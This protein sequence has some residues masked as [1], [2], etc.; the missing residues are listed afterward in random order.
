MGYKIG[1]VDAWGSLIPAGTTDKWPKQFW[2]IFERYGV[3][4]RFTKGFTAEQI[5]A[6]MDEADVEW[7]VLSAFGYGDFEI[8]TNEMV[9]ELVR[10]HPD[11][12]VGAGT[13]DP[14]GKPMDVTAQVDYLVNDLGLRCIRLEPYAYGN[15]MT[16]APPGEK[17][18]WP[19][20]IKACELGVPVAIQVGHTGPLLPSECGRPIYLDE[21]ALAFPDLKIL[22]CHLGQPWHEEMMILAWK[23]PNLYVETSARYASHWPESFTKFAGSYGQDKVVWATDYPLCGFK[24]AYDDVVKLGFSD[25]ANEKILRT[26]AMRVF[27]IEA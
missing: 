8:C 6:E 19:V 11:R 14:R 2:S 25:E 16:G 21:V 20:Y 9:S 3:A 15:D 10:A 18:Y 23:H 24:R 12:F 26:N 5:L 22:G 1:A 7:L 4:E 27:G 17:M 13:I